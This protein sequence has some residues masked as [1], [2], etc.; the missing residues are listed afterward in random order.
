MNINYKEDLKE[1]LF[2]YLSEYP[3]DSP[4]FLDTISNAMKNYKRKITVE[5]SKKAGDCFNIH[6]GWI[7]DSKSFIKL[8]HNYK[9]TFL[10]DTIF[11]MFPKGK[12]TGHSSSEADLFYYFVELIKQKESIDY[13]WMLQAKG[14]EI[15]DWFKELIRINEI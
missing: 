11:L 12:V 10:I 4:E 8:P 14:K 2:K 1:Q 3:E 7:L 5:R 15:V 13:N 9:F 6:S